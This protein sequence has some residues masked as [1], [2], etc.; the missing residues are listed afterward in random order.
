[1]LPRHALVWVWQA[2]TWCRGHITAWIR[3]GTWLGWEC[4]IMPDGDSAPGDLRGG[5]YVYDPATIRPASAVRP[6][7]PTRSKGRPRER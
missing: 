1:V 7:R 5:R 3:P 4:Q 2:G 6:P